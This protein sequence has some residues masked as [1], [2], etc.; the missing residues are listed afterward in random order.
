MA[1][2]ATGKDAV[3][4]GDCGA[5]W[6]RD[7]ALS[8]CSTT[9]PDDEIAWNRSASME[10]E[11]QPQVTQVPDADCEKAPDASA[12]IMPLVLV[13]LAAVITWLYL[14]W[15]ISSVLWTVGMV[16]CM[17]WLLLPDKV[18]SVLITS[19]VLPGLIALCFAIFVNS[20]MPSIS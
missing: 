5:D 18:S 17:A 4:T 16:N 15:F 1:T 11:S 20:G 19:F 10:S 9:V 2:L 13:L 12:A 14:P 7:R 6:A 8:A 3:C